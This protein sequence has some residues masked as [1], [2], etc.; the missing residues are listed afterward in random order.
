MNG[1][2][3]YKE[4]IHEVLNVPVLSQRCDNSFLN[5]TVACSADWDAHCVVTAQAIELAS[6][7]SRVISELHTASLA[8][9][10][11]RVKA[12]PL[13]FNVVP[14]FDDRMALNAQHT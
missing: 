13:V 11:V 8:V 2:G 12:V 1:R 10:V 6:Y 4:N 14:I 3:E 9:E 7:F 5:G